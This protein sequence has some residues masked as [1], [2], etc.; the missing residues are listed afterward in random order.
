MARVGVHEE[1]AVVG[2]VT[3]YEARHVIRS[4]PPEKEQR[5]AALAAKRDAGSL[6]ADERAEL[7]LLIAASEQLTIDNARA[8]LRYRSPEAY[9]QTIRD[10]QA[11]LTRHGQRKARIDGSR[12]RTK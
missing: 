8:L 11:A 7:R 3:D 12:T 1:A 5:Y 4:F 9:A 10:E 2:P 6:T